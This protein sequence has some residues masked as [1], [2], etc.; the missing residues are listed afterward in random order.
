MKFSH[1]LHMLLIKLCI[2]FPNALRPIRRI[3][4]GNILKLNLPPDKK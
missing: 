1:N 2:M 3:V 4:F